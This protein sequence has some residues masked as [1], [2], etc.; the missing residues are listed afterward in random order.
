VIQVV[1]GDELANV[2]L[3]P[4]P[5]MDV[6]AQHGAGQQDF[7]LAIPPSKLAPPLL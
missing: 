6:G 3:L 2:P 5:L 1:P 7:G 4:D